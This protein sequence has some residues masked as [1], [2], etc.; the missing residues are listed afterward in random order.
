VTAAISQ[1]AQT[2]SQTE[3][4]ESETTPQTTSQTEPVESETTPQTTPQTEPV[5]SETTPQ[6]TS[7]AEADS[8]I[9]TASPANAPDPLLAPHTVSPESRASSL[10]PSSMQSFDLAS[11]ADV[12]PAPPALEASSSSN[13]TSSQLSQ[14]AVATSQ[15]A[16]VIGLPIIFGGAA[17]AIILIVGSTVAYVTNQPHH[18]S[19]ESQKGAGASRAPSHARTPTAHSNQSGKLMPA[20]LAPSA[21]SHAP[22]EKHKQ[23]HAA[24]SKEP[25]AGHATEKSAKRHM[26]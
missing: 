5:E 3:P 4:V 21:A 1:S 26:S 2:I 10:V 14:S 25:S 7:A 24:H 15:P 13:Q 9:D 18:G 6:T 19:A 12:A 11:G 16:P 22:A 8:L 23:K 20:P 17:A